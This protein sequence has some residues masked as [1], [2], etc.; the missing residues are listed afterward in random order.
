VLEE[1]RTESKQVLKK[2]TAN[3]LTSMLMGVVIRG[4]GTAAQT[5]RP[6]AG[7]TGTTSDYHDAWFVGYVPDLVVGV[8]VGTD[9]NQR[10]GTMTGGTTPAVIWKAFMTKAMAG[11]PVK[12]FDGAVLTSVEAPVKDDTKE[13]E[14]KDKDKKGTEKKGAEKPA[15]TESTKP[16]PSPDPSPSRTP[17]PSP[18]A[19]AGKTAN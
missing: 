1:D 5:E 10:M 13:K 11:M 7:K 8:W 17:A 14:T 4:T 16:K 18:T 19:P 3:D 12:K 6:A 15:N 2:A 9:D